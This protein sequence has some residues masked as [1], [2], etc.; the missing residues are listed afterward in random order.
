MDA[1]RWASSSRLTFVL[2][3]SYYTISRIGTK[4]SLVIHVFQSS[5]CLHI[6]K[7]KG[8]QNSDTETVF[9]DKDNSTGSETVLFRSKSSS[10]ALQPPFVYRAVETG[11][12]KQ[13][14]YRM[15]GRWRG[16]RLTGNRTYGRIRNQ[17]G[18]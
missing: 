18:R 17:A 5:P 3:S 14:N 8:K 16:S 12:L 2:I 6:R 4:V 1:N 11:N 13:D 15:K 10:N 7:M 9:P